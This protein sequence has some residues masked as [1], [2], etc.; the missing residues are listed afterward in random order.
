M[1][2]PLDTH[3][4]DSIKTWLLD[5]MYLED[6]SFEFW[7]EYYDISIENAT[8]LNSD[9]WKASTLWEELRKPVPEIAIEFIERTDRL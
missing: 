8:V 1:F 5:N 9:R 2:K 6:S 7:V 4:N 3:I